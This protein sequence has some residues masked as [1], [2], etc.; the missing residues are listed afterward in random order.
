MS[1]F[2]FFFFAG[3]VSGNVLKM[4]WRKR[5]LHIASWN[6]NGFKYKGH[7]K[8]KD[9][10]FIKEFKNKD[11]VCLMETHCSLEECLN[12]SGFHAIHLIRPM[13]KR[14]NKRS[15]GLSI[16]VKHKLRAGVKF[17]EH[18]NNDYIW[19]KLNKSFFALNE[20][21]YLC[22]VYD[23]P[24][25]SSYTL[26][27]NEEI[28]DLIEKD[29]SNFSKKGNV[30]LAGDFNTRSTSAEQ[31]FIVNETFNDNVPLYDDYCPDVSVPTRITL[32]NTTTARGKELNELCIQSGLRILNGRV[33]GDL[34]GQFTCHTPRGS[35]VV[36]YMMVSECLFHRISFFKVSN[37]HAEFSDHCLISCMLN[38][39][40]YISDTEVVLNDFPIQYKWDE[41]SISNFQAALSSKQSKIQAFES[42]D[43]I[44][45]LFFAIL[46]QKITNQSN[47]T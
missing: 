42:E 34:T 9:S 30:I 2:F 1:C 23:P 12:V 36:D 43:L 44:G 28:L 4:I 14:T 45:R 40:C 31:D 32:D 18:R 47:R 19:L 20:D 16:F 3:T 25:S 13:S 7:S 35:S 24:S 6:I 21:I 15:G 8:Y 41:K 26:S 27:L 38:V 22:F 39:N 10:S 17:L 33:V 46:T 29:I 37:F 11:I 5:S